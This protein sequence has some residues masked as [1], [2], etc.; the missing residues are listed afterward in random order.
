MLSDFSASIMMFFAYR[1][2]GDLG[3]NLEKLGWQFGLCLNAI[4]LLLVSLM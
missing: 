3:G 4:P 1:M 2:T